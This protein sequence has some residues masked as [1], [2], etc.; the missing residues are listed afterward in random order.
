MSEAEISAQME[1]NARSRSRVIP[2]LLQRYMGSLAFAKRPTSPYAEVLGEP[3]WQEAREL[4]KAESGGLLNMPRESPLQACI[5]AGAIALPRLLKLS[6]VLQ[7]KYIEA[8]HAG[9]VPVDLLAGGK[10]DPHHS[11][12]TCP[13]SKE[14]TTHDNPPMLLLCGHVVALGSIAKLARGSRSV[15]FKCPYCPSESTSSMAK[16]LHL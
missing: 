16:V 2:E 8:W 6:S 10:Q 9:A 1:A 3:L 7:G 5:D 4:F 15:R 12:F 11:V 13:V 14:Q